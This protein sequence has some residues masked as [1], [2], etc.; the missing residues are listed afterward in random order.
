MK[1]Q[2]KTYLLF[3]LVIIVW[4]MIGYRMYKSLYVTKETFASENFRDSIFIPEKIK[5]R[6][7]YSIEVNYRD[8]FLGK[9]SVLKKKKKTTK[10]V[11]KKESV[12]FPSILY[13]GVVEGG[14]VK[15]Y[16][17][18]INNR[19]KMLKL[20]ETIESVK[21]L[22]AREDKIFISFKGIRKTIELSK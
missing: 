12:V 4:S 18:S 8:P 6:E 13:H 7:P 19:Q 11:I 20:R 5:E 14:G 9:L 21:L 22:R 10:K 17:I 16:V 15:S 3:L 1:K 2:Q